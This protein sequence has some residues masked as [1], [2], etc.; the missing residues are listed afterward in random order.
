MDIPD[1]NLQKKGCLVQ[2]KGQ[3]PSW[4]KQFVVL[5]YIMNI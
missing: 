3:R 1:L 4:M 2:I 5:S